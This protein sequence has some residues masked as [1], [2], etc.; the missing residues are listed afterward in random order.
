MHLKRADHRR[1]FRDCSAASPRMGK[2]SLVVFIVIT[3][4][5]MTVPVAI[6]HLRLRFTRTRRA[7]VLGRGITGL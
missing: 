4:I 1:Q 5:G 7:N 3:S 2:S 6:F